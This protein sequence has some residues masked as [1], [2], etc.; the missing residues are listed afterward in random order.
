[1]KR[2]ASFILCL[3]LCLALS[4]S[5]LDSA[6]GGRSEV[7]ELSPSEAAAYDV[8][9]VNT[10]NM[11]SSSM[12]SASVVAQILEMCEYVGDTKV[13]DYVISRYS[14]KTLADYLHNCKII[15]DVSV[16]NGYLYIIYETTD[17]INVTLCYID[18][19]LNDKYVY[20][21]ATDIV[22]ID[23]GGTTVLQTRFRQGVSN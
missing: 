18:S 13:A 22:F 3:L 23:A 16:M 21:K 19:G 20:N 14:P 8:F 7:I 2:F 17:D 10:G 1:M 12:H 9:E 5:G 11:P 6:F 15:T 4:F